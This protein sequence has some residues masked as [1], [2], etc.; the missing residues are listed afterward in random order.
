[1]T[2]PSSLSAHPGSLPEALDAS[3][4]AGRPVRIGLIGAGQMG[5]DIVVQTAHMPGI[6]VAAVA[7]ATPD[8]VL[9]ACKVAGDGPRAPHVV[10]GV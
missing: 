6:E 5:T 2:P 7:D 9:A 4:R 10:D 8:V 1:M 3:R